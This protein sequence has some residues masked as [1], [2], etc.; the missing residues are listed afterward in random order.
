MERDT[1]QKNIEENKKSAFPWRGTN[2][3]A[4]SD[5]G[6][7]AAEQQVD[8]AFAITDP[9]ADERVKAVISNFYSGGV[10]YVF[11]DEPNVQWHGTAATPENYWAPQLTEDLQRGYGLCAPITTARAPRPLNE[12][13]F[14]FFHNYR[15]LRYAQVLTCAW[16]SSLP[17]TREMHR[18]TLNPF[19]QAEYDNFFEAC[20]LHNL[21]SLEDEDWTDTPTF[22]GRSTAGPHLRPTRRAV[23]H[24]IEVIAHVLDALQGQ[25]DKA[26]PYLQDFVGEDWP[27]LD[28]A[29][30]QN[31]I[32]GDR[33]K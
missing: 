6:P 9:I 33:T 2:V 26:L 15:F 29:M 1:Q 24:C 11:P 31:D 32:T 19:H 4:M 27:D 18:Q 8:D 21:I 17:L 14:L 28:L 7:S 22:C 13:T 30:P 20:Q 5:Y 12:Y 25:Y 3:V 23:Y 10:L 16:A